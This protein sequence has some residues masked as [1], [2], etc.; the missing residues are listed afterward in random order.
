MIITQMYNENYCSS[1]KYRIAEGVLLSDILFLYMKFSFTFVKQIKCK[2]FLKFSG[3]SLIVF[4]FSLHISAQQIVYSQPDNDDPRSVNF[5]IIG[6][7]NDHFLVYKTYGTKYKICL[8]DNDLKLSAKNDMPF[9]PDRIIN[10]DFIVYRDFFYFIY[11][12]QKK[13]I[14]YCMAAKMDAN[15]N[16]VGNPLQLDTA[17]INF[18]ASNKIYN[19]TYS[20][21]KQRIDV[22]KIN[23]KDESNFGLTNILF[24]GSLKLL[25]KTNSNIF[26][27]ER[28]NSLNDFE[29]DN[30][31]CLVFLRTSGTSQNDNINLVTLITKKP[32][33]TDVSYYSLPLTNVY[34]DEIHVKV[35]N[36]NKHYLVTS[37]FSKN[38]HGNIEGLYA[39][40]WSRDEDSAKAVSYVTLSDDLRN[41]AKSQG[42]NIRIAFND[43][44]IQN[45]IMRNDGGFIIASE[46]AS[47]TSR[48]NPFNRWD[49]FNSPYSYPGSYYY[50]N[51]YS[52][53]SLY[54]PWYN[55]SM[56]FPEQ[57]QAVRYFADNIC[58]LSF[59]SS[60]NMEWSTIANKSQ[61]D[62]NTD[63][64]LGYYLLNT[65]GELHFIFNQME[66]R[67]NLLSDQ[68]VTPDGQLHISPT[69]RN[70]DNIYEFMPKHSKQVGSHELLIPCVYRNYICFAKV[71]F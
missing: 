21:D 3:L 17:Q 10:S 47:S 69:F 9:V 51:P 43:Y 6:K 35:D 2:M 50:A 11:Q 71:D 45:I 15:G 42:E 60:A 19:L 7:M 23:T 46:A 25:S 32:L 5:D 56:M 27:P 14:V 62:D 34:L 55:S 63:N 16:I 61:Y 41:Q 29:V 65:G 12:Y 59:D 48:G 66:R 1:L 67:Q 57:Y 30:D 37:F 53:N 70:L 58:V 31:G 28:N 26:I 18:L 36:K 40:L 22:F 4:F 38:H 54:Y 24:D 64:F 39:A 44:Y 68:S 8:Y 52:Y 13:N 20:E 49:Y 33:E